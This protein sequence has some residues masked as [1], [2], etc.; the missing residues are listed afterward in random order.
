MAMI[1]TKIVRFSNEIMGIKYG[2]DF[3]YQEAMTFPRGKFNLIR[4]KVFRLGLGLFS[5]IQKI[6]ILSL[7]FN[8]LFLPKPGEGPSKIKREGGYFNLTLI[9]KG[10][11][12]GN[13]FKVVGT[14][15][16][17]KDPGYAGTA[18]MI[19]EA[20]ICLSKH[21]E[22]LPKKFGVLTP[23]SAIGKN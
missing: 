13:N 12:N 5:F 6:K 1:N 3:S 10:I 14:I 20:A 2:K 21:K 22:K 7:F 9:G 11:K 4:A 23:A 17:D 15:Y 19:G 16:G 18:R 8:K